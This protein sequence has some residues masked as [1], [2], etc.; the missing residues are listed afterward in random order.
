[1]PDS[2]R[3][4]AQ[5]ASEGRGMDKPDADVAAKNRERQELYEQIGRLKVENN[6]PKKSAL[7]S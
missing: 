4:V 7:G 5:A 2:D 6:F 1:M 3:Q